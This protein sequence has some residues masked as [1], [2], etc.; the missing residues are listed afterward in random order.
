M[1]LSVRR[2]MLRATPVAVVAL[3]AIGSSASTASAWT[4]DPGRVTS[5]ANAYWS[6]MNPAF[7]GFGDDC[8]NYVS[9]TLYYGGLPFQGSP[10][11]SGGQNISNQWWANSGSWTFSWSIADSL[12]A[13]LANYRGFY[14]SYSHYGSGW[15]ASPAGSRVGA[16]I[17]YNWGNDPNYPVPAAQHAGIVTYVNTRDPNSGYTGTLVNTHSNA[18][19]Q[20]IWTL[21]PYNSWYATTTAAVYTW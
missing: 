20:A 13:Y 3:L 5:Y 21:A 8:T 9:Q 19:A 15:A 10:F 14:T 17:F 11:G 6:T 4:I 18:H 1:K 16:V 2:L 7:P 12:R